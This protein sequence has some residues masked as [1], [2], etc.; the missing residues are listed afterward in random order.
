MLAVFWMIKY[1]NIFSEKSGYWFS[2]ERLTRTLTTRC[3]FHKLEDSG[4]K[5]SISAIDFHPWMISL[6][7]SLIT[8]PANLDFSAVYLRFKETVLNSSIELSKVFNG[9]SWKP[10]FLYTYLYLLTN[11][12]NLHT[13]NRPTCSLPAYF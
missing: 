1:S 13:T 8:L 3:R 12:P 5:K 10:R 9:A 11:K 7:S 6:G 2:S 4:C